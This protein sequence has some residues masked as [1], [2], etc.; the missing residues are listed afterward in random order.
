MKTF[1]VGILGL[2]TVGGGTYDILTKNKELIEK[3]TGEHIT[4]PYLADEAYLTELVGRH[5]PESSR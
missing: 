2:G 5:T 1:N 3:R 4:L